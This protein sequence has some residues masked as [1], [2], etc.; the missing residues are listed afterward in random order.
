MLAWMGNLLKG[1][2]CEGVPPDKL[3]RQRQKEAEEA[4]GSCRI[5]DAKQR[6]GD[7]LRWS[8][9]AHIDSLIRS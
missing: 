7:L 4:C 3:L 6:R 2:V 8:M 5:K 9:T 1:G